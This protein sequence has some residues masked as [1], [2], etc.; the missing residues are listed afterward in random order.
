MAASTG[1]ISREGT[2]NSAFE[3]ITYLRVEMGLERAVERER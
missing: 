2:G 3:G 1:V